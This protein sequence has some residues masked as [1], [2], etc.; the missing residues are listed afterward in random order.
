MGKSE[1]LRAF[2]SNQ[3]VVLDDWVVDLASKFS[4]GFI[5]TLIWIKLLRETNE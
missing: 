1:D 3:I 5:M 2:N 4:C